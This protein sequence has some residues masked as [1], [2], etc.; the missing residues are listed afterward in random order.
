[1]TNIE[2][3][4][5]KELY[6]FK[7]IGHN[8][9]NLNEQVIGIG[10]GSGFETPQGASDSLKKFTKRQEMGEQ[11][12]V[13]LDPDA[14]TEELEGGEEEMGVDIE[15]DMGDEEADIEGVRR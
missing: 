6:R 14:E 15:D 9:D 3:E 4:L 5:I 7:E 1:M 12:D 13:E 10:G 2:N 8:S 11:E